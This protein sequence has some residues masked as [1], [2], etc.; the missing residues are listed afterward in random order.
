[1]PRLSEDGMSGDTLDRARAA[2]TPLERLGA[3]IPGFRG[4][5]ERELRR[6]VDQLLRA[7]V[8]GRIDAARLRLAGYTRSLRLSATGRI[9][10][11]S[12][13]DKRLDG[14]ANAIRHAGSGYSGLFDAT[15][16]R[17]AELDAL[18]SSDLALVEVADQLGEIAGRLG[19]DDS[20]LAELEAACER[21]T[22]A[23]SSRDAAVKSVIRA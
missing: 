11:A 7:E 23:A 9:A 10:S 5:L 4:Y 17:V 19:Q 8:A 14:L 12:S 16:I 13:L 22:Q 2:R 15:K 3:R 6:E 1:M 20:A 18:Y 21:A